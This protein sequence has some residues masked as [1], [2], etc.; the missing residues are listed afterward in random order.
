MRCMSKTG[1]TYEGKTYAQGDVF[2]LPHCGILTELDDLTGFACVNGVWQCQAESCDCMGTRVA[3]G[4]ACTPDGPYACKT[5]IAGAQCKQGNIFC[6]STPAPNKPDG[7]ICEHNLWKCNAKA[8][9]CGDKTIYKD[10]LCLNEDLG[11]ERVVEIDENLLEIDAC[12]GFID[13]D[14]IRHYA[15]KIGLSELDILYAT[16]GGSG[17]TTQVE[18][19]CNIER[20]C[21]VN[22]MHLDYEAKY[23]HIKYYTDPPHYDRIEDNPSGIFDN[24]CVLDNVEK[25]QDHIPFRNVKTTYKPSIINCGHYYYISSEDPE[26][27]FLV[28]DDLGEIPAKNTPKTPT[29]S[30]DN[31]SCPGGSF[32]CG[33]KDNKPSKRPENGAGYECLEFQPKTDD[34]LPTQGGVRTWVCANPKGCTC[35]GQACPL[36]SACVN[37]SCVAPA[38]EFVDAHSKSCHRNGKYTADGRCLCN[39]VEITDDNYECSETGIVYCANFNCACGQNTCSYQETCSE[40]R[41]LCRG[42]ENPI[43]GSTSYQCSDGQWV[44]NSDACK[45][46]DNVCSKG[47][48]CS[49]GQCVC[50]PDKHPQPKKLEGYQCTTNPK[51]RRHDAWICKESTGCECGGIYCPINNACINETCYCSSPNE[52]FKPVAY[53]SPNNEGYTCENI[54]VTLDASGEWLNDTVVNDWVCNK[55]EGCQCGSTV[56]PTNTRCHSGQCICG[57]TELARGYACDRTVR[58]DDGNAMQ[59]GTQVCENDQCKCGGK[60]CP[61]N[62]MCIDN[63]CICSGTLNTSNIEDYRCD[64]ENLGGWPETIRRTWMCNKPEGCACGSQKCFGSATCNNGQCEC[65]NTASPGPEWICNF[66]WTCNKIE[67]CMAGG[68]LI[69]SGNNYRACPYVGYETKKDGCYC[70]NNKYEGDIASEYYCNE[71]NKSLVCSKSLCTADNVKC[72]LGALL[73]DGKCVHKNTKEPLTTQDGYISNGTLR[74]CINED[75]C[76]CGLETCPQGKACLMGHTLHYFGYNTDELIIQDF[77]FQLP[78][79]NLWKL[80]ADEEYDR[81]PSKELFSMQDNPEIKATIDQNYG[82]ITFSYSPILMSVPVCLNP[83]GCPCGNT[84]CREGAFCDFKS[85]ACIY[86]AAYAEQIC[87]YAPSN[88]DEDE[89]TDRLSAAKAGISATADGLCVCRG[90]IRDPREMGYTCSAYGWSCTDA[91]GCACG[92]ATCNQGAFCVKPGVCVE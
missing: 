9:L 83:A 37:G 72:P 28:S 11:R 65:F 74:V 60:A 33:G 51:V 77:H 87:N 49:N 68:K 35:N 55:E 14:A 38:D 75:G 6:S 86:G 2:P 16:D 81:D 36:Y 56:C 91:Q 67:G 34:V 32:L 40:G 27:C 8:C 19:F 7:Y 52:A 24:V 13:S 90:T 73:V 4:D 66:G 63:E 3:Q 17:C 61:K 5:V 78:N 23:S 39:G 10:A 84:T 46:G 85:S 26:L 62:A 25:D 43:P 88:D 71:G 58:N 30:F 54:Q 69:R 45:C 82:M 76:Q 50:G 31:Q 47:S 42:A 29:F 44:C 22:G 79:Y 18:F 59:D 20:G 70:G 1:C 41:C 12:D 92:N 48:I 57:T 80:S 21:Y 53:P 89:S 15:D 64:V